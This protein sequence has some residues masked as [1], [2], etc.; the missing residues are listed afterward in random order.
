MEDYKNCLE[1]RKLENEKNY[2]EKN[3]VKAESIGENQN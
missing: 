3:K 2:L 1:P